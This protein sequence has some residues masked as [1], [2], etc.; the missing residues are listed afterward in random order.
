MRILTRLSAIIRH[1]LNRLSLH[2]TDNN[3]RIPTQ[4]GSRMSSLVGSPVHGDFSSILL[5]HIYIFICIYIYN[6]YIY[7][8][9]LFMNILDYLAARIKTSP[10]AA[11]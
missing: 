1:D 2:N 10:T 4:Q 8:Y 7:T 9:P 3:D 11:G 5:Q 6:I